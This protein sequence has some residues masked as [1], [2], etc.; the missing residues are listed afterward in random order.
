MNIKTLKSDK[1]DIRK[2]LRTVETDM[3]KIEL[4]LK[5]LRQKEIRAKRQIEAIDVLIEIDEPKKDAS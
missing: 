4:E 5:G 3:R 1:E 2:E